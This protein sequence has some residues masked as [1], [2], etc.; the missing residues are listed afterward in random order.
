MERRLLNESVG[1]QEPSRK[2]VEDVQ[3]QL[4]CGNVYNF[5]SDLGQKR[6]LWGFECDEDDRE[7]AGRGELGDFEAL[8]C[9]I[10]WGLVDRNGRSGARRDIRIEAR[11]VD[12]NGP[13]L[14][15]ELG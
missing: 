9:E 15:F 1:L 4:G 10:E 12:R 6:L 14:V 5:F 11:A 3:H 13:I 7:R 8:A 2:V